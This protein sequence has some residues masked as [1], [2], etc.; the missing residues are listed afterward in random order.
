VMGSLV[1]VLLHIFLDSDSEIICEN[2]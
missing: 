1:T 2:R